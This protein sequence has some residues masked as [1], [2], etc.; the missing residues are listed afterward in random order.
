MDPN[1]RPPEEDV[2]DCCRFQAAGWFNENGDR[3]RWGSGNLAYGG[4]C[5]D[6]MFL[7]A[8]NEIDRLNSQARPY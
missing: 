8:A 4:S 5:Q 3:A 1:W 7:I 2:A 6:G